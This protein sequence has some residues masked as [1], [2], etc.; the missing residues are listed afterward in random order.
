MDKN[1][2]EEEDTPEKKEDEEHEVRE[3][4]KNIDL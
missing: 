4:E 2:S 1:E 3:L